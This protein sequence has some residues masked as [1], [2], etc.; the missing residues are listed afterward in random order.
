MMCALNVCVYVCIYMLDVHECV[1]LTAW[2]P[3][4]SS[5]QVQSQVEA[6]SGV[7]AQTENVATIAAPA[8]VVGA[9]LIGVGVA[10]VAVIFT[11]QW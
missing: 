4:P 5:V 3:C 8:V 6:T 2:P 10:A 7:Q 9:V 11:L 1:T